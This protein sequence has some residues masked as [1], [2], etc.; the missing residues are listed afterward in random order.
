MN[1]IFD[2]RIADFRLLPISNVGGFANRQSAIAH[3]RDRKSEF[4]NMIDWKQEIRHRLAGLKLEPVRE[5]EIVEELSQHLEDR[6]CELLSSGSTEEGAHGAVLAELSQIDLLTRKLR[7]VENAVIQEPV[8]LGA[9]EENF[10]ICDYSI[11]V[12]IRLISV[13]RGLYRTGTN[14]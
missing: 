1:R 9:N 2:F 8:I 7:R 11:S 10:A 6:Y 3:N 4:D 5:I 12:L 14:S 13:I